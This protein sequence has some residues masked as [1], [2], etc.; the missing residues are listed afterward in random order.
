MAWTTSATGGRTMTWRHSR[1]AKGAL[2][3][4]HLGLLVVL[5]QASSAG[6]P[7]PGAQQAAMALQPDLFLGPNSAAMLVICTGLMLT[8]LA[9]HSTLYRA[10]APA[11]DRFL[12]A[13]SPPVPSAPT[14]LVNEQSAEAHAGLI[15]RLNHDLRTPL[16]AIIGFADLM[17]S[18]AF[19]PID[20]DRYRNYVAHMQSCGHDL[21]RATESTLAMTAILS[22]PAPGRPETFKLAVLVQDAWLIATAGR[23]VAPPAL[24]I[25]IGSDVDA[26]ADYAGMRQS[27]INLLGAA[28]DRCHSGSELEFTA[29]SSHGRIEASLSV[30]KRNPDYSPARTGCRPATSAA[31]TIEDLPITLSRT[32]LGL[33]GIP[34]VVTTDTPGQ[35]VVA[36]SIED[37]VQ[38]DFFDHQNHSVPARTRNQIAAAPSQSYWSYFGAFSPSRSA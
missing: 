27:L 36:L 14:R 29:R 32:L 15:A 18:E 16:N 6:E 22:N 26:R 38:T 13:T 8:A 1:A 37:A 30:S 35:W 34:L 2:L 9:M 28:C 24:R 12:A 11:G 19:G 4:T 31:V 21:L 25:T 20:N 7:L 17:K 33:Q 10:A 3:V 23:S 5:V